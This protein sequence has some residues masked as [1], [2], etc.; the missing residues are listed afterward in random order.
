[1]PWKGSL[2]EAGER[3]RHDGGAAALNDIPRFEISHGVV[4][5][6]GEE[7]HADMLMRGEP[8]F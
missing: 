2:R 5:E 8:Q 6:S 1:M 3:T 4:E 7:S